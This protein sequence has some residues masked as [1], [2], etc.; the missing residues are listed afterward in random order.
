M[1]D[2][3]NL[4]DPDIIR[5]ISHEVIKFEFRRILPEAILRAATAEY[6]CVKC[7]DVMVTKKE[8]RNH[9]QLMHKEHLENTVPAEQAVDQEEN[10]YL[11]T[12]RNTRLKRQIYT[13]L[14]TR[15]KALQFQHAER[16]TFNIFSENHGN[17]AYELTE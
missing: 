13:M 11:K 5:K 15:Q 3:V 17:A 12:L 4:V 2:I 10:E 14:N 8:L 16:I 7:C 9:M 6:F 1:L